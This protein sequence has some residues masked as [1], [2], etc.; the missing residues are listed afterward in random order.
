M[1]IQEQLQA[2]FELIKHELTIGECV[3]FERFLSEEDF[4]GANIYLIHLERKVYVP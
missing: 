2:R 4:S 1:D 3:D